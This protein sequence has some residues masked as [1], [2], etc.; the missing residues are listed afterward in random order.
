MT[1][2]V[3]TLAILLAGAAGT[4][5]ALALRMSGIRTDAQD[6]DH[7][8]EAAEKASQEAADALEDARTRHASQLEEIRREI[9]ELEHDLEGCECSGM[10]R[11]RL[12]RL[13]SKAKNAQG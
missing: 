2:A 4:A 9:G 8:R 11:A 6:A 13:L 10:R 12:E 3:V 7:K 5:V 1:A